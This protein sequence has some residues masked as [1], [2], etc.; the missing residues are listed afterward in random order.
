MAL[1]SEHPPTTRPVGAP[2]KALESHLGH[3]TLIEFNRAM[4]RWGSRGALDERGGAVLCAGGTW[5]P[6]VANGAFRSEESLSGVELVAR[7]DAFFAGIARGFT[8]KVRDIRAPPARRRVWR[9]SA[10]PCPR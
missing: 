5:I 2:R 6:V 10:R 1:R 8:V 3:R 4:T 9:P 7:A